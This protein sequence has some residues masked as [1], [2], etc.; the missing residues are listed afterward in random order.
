MGYLLMCKLPFADI[1]SLAEAVTAIIALLALIVSTLTLVILY[2]NLG[3]F[4]KQ[5]SLTQA[6]NRPLC[7]IKDIVVSVHSV[8]PTPTYVIGLEAVIVNSGNDFARDVRMTYDI[9]ALDATKSTRVS[10][11]TKKAG[12]DDRK[13]TILP[14]HE[15]RTFL[16]YIKKEDFDQAVLGYDKIAF[17]E[18]SLEYKNMDGRVMKYSCV[19]SISRLLTNQDMKVYEVVLRESKLVES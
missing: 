14:R 4:W 2:C 19:Y 1:G 8:P 17:L 7:G 16:L 12:Q 15:I 3:Q 13:W 9:Y 6:L 11:A 18:M 5:N 10:L